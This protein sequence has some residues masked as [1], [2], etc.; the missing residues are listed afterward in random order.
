MEELNFKETLIKYG[1]RAMLNQNNT[2]SGNVSRLS[3]LAISIYNQY[4]KN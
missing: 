3:S 2:E 4:Y 1:S